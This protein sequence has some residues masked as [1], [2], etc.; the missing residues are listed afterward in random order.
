LNYARGGGVYIARGIF[1]LFS[2]FFSTC[3]HNHPTTISLKKNSDGRKSVTDE[4]AIK[5]YC[6]DD[7][8]PSTIFLLISKKVGDE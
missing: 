6:G 2:S 8:F 3:F 7:E 4:Y 1:L 5:N